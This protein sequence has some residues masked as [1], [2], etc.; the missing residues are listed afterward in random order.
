MVYAIVGAVIA[1]AMPA[2]AAPPDDTV[3]PVPA[4]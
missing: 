4:W 2:I 3:V 1:L